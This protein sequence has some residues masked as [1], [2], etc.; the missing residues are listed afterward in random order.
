MLVSGI[1]LSDGKKNLK[2]N[3][4]KSM[5][6]YSLAIIGHWLI[7]GIEYSSLCYTVGPCCVSIIYIVVCIC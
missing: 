7:Q 5:Y 1:Q 4:K 6:I 3:L 2:K